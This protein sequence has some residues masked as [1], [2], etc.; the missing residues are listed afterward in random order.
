MCSLSAKIRFMYSF[1]VF[2]HIWCC[3]EMV[4]LVLCT[5]YGIPVRVVT[6]AGWSQQK[7]SNIICS[8]EE[9]CTDIL[10]W[11]LPTFYWFCQSVNLATST[12]VP[13]IAEFTNLFDDTN[14]HINN[15]KH[16]TV[17]IISH[18]LGY[19]FRSTWPSS[20]PSEAQCSS[21]E[22]SGNADI[23]LLEH[24]AS[25]AMKCLVTQTFHC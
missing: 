17:L 23:S 3:L 22:M 12:W 15:V 6:L 9:V 19:R 24:C 8:I 5:V 11:I 2:K 18:I 13:A 1:G 20:G 21:N 16:N 4:H 7:L 14:T 10:W 25:N